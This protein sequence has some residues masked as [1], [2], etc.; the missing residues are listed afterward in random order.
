MRQR[1]ALVCLAVTLFMCQVQDAKGN[2]A[3][4]DGY[5]REKQMLLLFV[6]GLT[7][8]DLQ[9]MR[10]DPTVDKWISQA[11]AGAVSLRLPGPR[12]LA[13]AYLLM[14][15]GAQALYTEKSGT[16]HHRDELLDGGQTA[17]EQA[18][19]FGV[20]LPQT[21]SQIVFPGIYRLHA[22][23]QDKPFTPSIGRLGG[24]LAAHKIPVSVY[25]N[26]DT[27][28]TQQR[29]VALFAMDEHGL[30]PHGDVSP[31][32]QERAAAYPYG[33]KTNYQY[34]LERI[35]EDQD[36]GL[37]AVQL[38]DLE[39]LYQ[40]A[41]AMQPD[42]FEQQYKQ[43]LADLS[44]FLTRVLEERTDYQAVMLVS[45][46]VHH[47]AVEEKKL[48]SP[49]LVWN[50]SASGLLTSATT[51]QPGLVSGLDLY[52]TVLSW[53]DV[54]IPGGIA[55]HPVR[56]ASGTEPGIGPL[57]EQ[58]DEIHHTYATRAPV[59]YTYVMLQMITL[60]SAAFLW[61]WGKRAGGGSGRE[62]L[63]KGVRLALLTML[64]FP[65]LLLFEGMLSWQ[66]SAPVILGGLIMAGLLLAFAMEQSPLP[67][68]VATVCGVTVAG[69]LADGW[70]GSSLMRGSYLGY[71]PVIGARFYGLGNEYEGV[72]IGS[73][74]LLIAALYQLSAKRRERAG[75]GRLLPALGAVALSFVVL[76]Y[77]VA[78][79]LGTDAGGF[80][81][82]LVAFFVAISRLEEWR[83]G[84]KGLLL[85]A[86]GLV[87]GV[88][89]LMAGSLLTDQ[90][91]THVGRVSQ[92]IVSGDWAEVGQMI[93]RKL[94]M[95]LRL[96]RVSIWSKVFVVSLVV[97]GILAL[98]N[99]RYLRH[100]ARDYPFLVKGFAGIIAGSLAGLALNDSGIVTAATCITFLV[101]PALYAALGETPS[102]EVPPEGSK[103][104]I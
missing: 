46:I 37:V 56:A 83:L 39:R 32:T 4:S 71:D 101:I 61:L 86:G 63:R 60:A 81:A 59:L 42:R 41:D 31:R 6:E 17:G 33:Q 14:G 7:F 98:W 49:I 77:M 50:G 99:D 78:P 12:N 100:L 45:P 54:P 68:V 29:H 65:A 52:P 51:R 92:Q 47:Q 95:N 70:S 104:Q 69:L 19:A 9:Q 76:Y 10:T 89:V 82:G 90:P 84:K 24:T 23:N 79:H 96:I 67:R 91:L 35:R 73:A 22:A 30:V 20:P 57:M 26:A 64:W 53:L 66:P 97:L 102:R 13:N 74:T 18:A 48:L 34:L 55:G 80:L 21:G 62:R 15:G 28:E 75:W 1:W 85:L 25:G 11:S 87:C 5:I 44:G 72:L 40:V 94:A 2:T 16:A 88:C 27:G 3:G 38:P 58:V 43:V 36:A 93:E 103:S 8:A